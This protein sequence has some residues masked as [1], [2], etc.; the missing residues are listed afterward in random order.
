MFRPRIF[1]GN[2]NA[3]VVELGIVPACIDFTDEVNGS[4]LFVDCG[5]LGDDV[6][7]AEDRDENQTQAVNTLAIGEQEKKEEYF[8]KIHVGFWDGTYI[9]YHPQMPHPYVDR[10]EVRPDNT[11]TYNMYSMRLAGKEMATTRTT[12][13]FVNQQR[14]FTFSFLAD[15]VPD[16]HSIFLIHGKK[17][18][19]EKITATFSAE[20]GRSRVLKIVCYQMFTLS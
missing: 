2:D 6:E 11:Y 20:T 9:K 12:H 17:Y 3:D 16:V 5:T 15:T 13:F 18:L 10:H 14:K 4:M 7:D 8:D 19:A 1:N